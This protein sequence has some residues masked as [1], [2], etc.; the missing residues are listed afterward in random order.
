VV[1]PAQ[2]AIAV[3]EAVPGAQVDVRRDGEVV[4]SETAPGVEMAAATAEPGSLMTLGPLDDGAYVVSQT[5]NGQRGLLSA[6]VELI[7]EVP[8]VEPPAPVAETPAPVAEPPAPVA[9]TPA[10][11]AEVAPPVEEAPAAE[12]R[13]PSVTTL[14]RTG[15]DLGVLPMVAV[16]LIALGVWATLMARL[17]G[18]R[19]VARAWSAGRWRAP[20]G[21]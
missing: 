16:L 17:G 13:G 19:A 21:N 18:H 8:T 3:L 20:G 9:E 1:E 4:L 14:P 6:P 11:V 5:V 12:A 15:A 7:T 2:G 10:P